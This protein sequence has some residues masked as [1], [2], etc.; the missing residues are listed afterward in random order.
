MLA[1]EAPPNWRF[2][3]LRGGI[4]GDDPGLGKTVTMLA[5]IVRSA[6]AQPAMPSEFWNTGEGWVQLRH[7]PVGHR[8]LLRVLNP[9]RKEFLRPTRSA[10]LMPTADA[11]A[12]FEAAFAPLNAF[13]DNGARSADEFPTMAAFEAQLHL[14]IREAVRASEEAT[15]RAG[16]GACAAVRAVQLKRLR[17][18][19][20]LALNEVRAGLDKRQ[21]AFY[22]SA[23]GKRALFERNL[24]PA[25]STLVVVPMA[26]L[27]HWYEQLRRHVDLRALQGR[28]DGGGARGAVWIDGLGDVADVSDFRMRVSDISNTDVADEYTLASY[29]VV[30]TTYDRCRGERAKVQHGGLGMAESP[31]MRL[32]WLR[33]VVD[34]G[35]EMGKHEARRPPAL[36][37]HA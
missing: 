27:E 15:V 11:V 36:R 19:A 1:A 25:A 7:N 13:A 18:P 6:G 23:T 5:L 35:H 10:A 8:R 22:A 14:C 28:P 3:E 32:R 21:R 29:T 9:L 24:L 30:L 26:L 2:G 34:E 31:L 12:R 4:L 20:R 17:E 16:G 33:L 37:C